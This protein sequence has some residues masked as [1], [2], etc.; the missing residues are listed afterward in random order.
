MLPALPPPV[1][2]VFY[3]PVCAPCRL[4]LPVLA[5][6][7]RNGNADRLRIVIISDEAR[8]RE[9]LRAVSPRLEA[10]AETRGD[11]PGET[12]RA[13]GNTSGILPY[14]RSVREEEVCAQ[15]EGRLTPQRIDMLL[16]ACE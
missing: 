9:D 14:A 13:S 7:M 16:A 3:S 4:E 15:W 11:S 5:D 12:L 10:R 2:E 8:A 6:Y 1:L